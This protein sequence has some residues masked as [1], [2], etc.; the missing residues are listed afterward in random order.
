[1]NVKN[2]ME[3]VVKELMY[4]II[5]DRDDICKC[6]KCL[7]DIAAIA[8]NNLPPHYVASEK[9]QVYAKVSSLSIQFGANVTKAIIN[10]IDTVTKNPR[11]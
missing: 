11:H 9:G 4:D 10:A 7:N 6:E 2:Y 3:D 5:E 1:M 8:L